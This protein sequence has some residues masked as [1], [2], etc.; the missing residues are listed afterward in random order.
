MRIELVKQYLSNQISPDKILY[1]EEL[2]STNNQAKRLFSIDSDALLIARRQTAGR[3]RMGRSFYSAE[4]EGIYMSYIYKPIGSLADNVI[5]TAATAVAVANS[6]IKNCHLNARIKWVNDILVNGK[7]VSG[8]LTESATLQ[9]GE[10][11]III[12]I[13]INT[14]VALFPDEL[15][16]IAGG[17]GHTDR[18]RLIADII[19]ALKQFIKELPLRTFIDD[20]RKLSCVLGQEIYYIKDGITKKARAVDIDR[21]G[22]LI[23]QSK[24]S[25][26]ITLNSGDISLRLK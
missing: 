4:D 16:N 21:N 22:G 1:F 23:V 26:L 25:R 19:F 18:E 7:K 5:V 11:I 15:K 6:I 20:Y 14:N 12:G 8:I 9:N 3:G 13:G 2:D 24:N 10:Q 17:I